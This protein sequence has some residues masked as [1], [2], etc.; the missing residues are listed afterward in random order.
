M[1]FDSH[2]FRRQAAGGSRLG[3]DEDGF[4]DT[5]PCPLE[6]LPGVDVDKDGLDFPLHWRAGE[7]S[8]LRQ[9]GVAVQALRSVGIG[10]AQQVS[11]HLISHILGSSTAHVVRFRNGGYVKII[12]AQDRSVLALE[13]EC[14]RAEVSV[15]G[16]VVITAW[17]RRTTA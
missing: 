13:G 11:S 15:D 5:V 16:D 10:D 1:P 6:T 17:D 2:W 4:P 12:Y 7:R 9:T 8:R 14:I 3:V